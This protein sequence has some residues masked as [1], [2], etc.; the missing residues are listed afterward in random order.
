MP[1]LLLATYKNFSDEE[2]SDAENYR[3]KN[4]DEEYYSEKLIFFDKAIWRISLL[5]EQF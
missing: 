3:E 4:S 1:L 2:N 5:R